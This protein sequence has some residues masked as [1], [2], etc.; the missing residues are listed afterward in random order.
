MG[1]NLKDA[2]KFNWGFLTNPDA[3]DQRPEASGLGVAII[4]SAY[5]MLLVALF[6]A[7]LTWASMVR[8]VVQVH[9]DELVLRNMLDTVALPLAAV[10]QVSI[11]QMLAIGTASGR[12]VS[13]AVGKS[14]RK[15]SKE[16]RAA[17]AGRPAAGTTYADYVEER[18]SQLAEDARAREGVALMSSEQAALAQQVRRQPAWPEIGALVVTAVA[19][20]ST[21]FADRPSTS[22]AATTSSHSTLRLTTCP[23]SN[24]VLTRIS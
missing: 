11:G 14:W 20:A 3:S 18:L 21:S 23:A 7:V 8:P 12:Y 5:M 17:K 15:A 2:V 4:G 16:N 9:G 19:A 10:E 24:A 1:I 6:V 22:P 13:P